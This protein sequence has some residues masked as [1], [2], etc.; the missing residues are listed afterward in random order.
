[1][2]LIKL[3]ENIT[4][5]VL[6]HD[7]LEVYG[8]GRDKRKNVKAVEKIFRYLK[9]SSGIDLVSASVS[10]SI[11]LSAAGECEITL[12]K[13]SY[14][15]EIRTFVFSENGLERLF[16]ALK[17]SD[18]KKNSS[19]YKYKDVYILEHLSSKDSPFPSRFSDFG[20]EITLSSRRDFLSGVCTRV[21]FP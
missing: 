19:I 8:V 6:N 15:L 7:E 17:N 21:N 14:R 10:V 11:R 4:R 16:F 3:S 20:R 5:L 1:M 2:E 12:K 9:E 13:S 18:F